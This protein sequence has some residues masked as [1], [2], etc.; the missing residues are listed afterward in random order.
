M[1]SPAFLFLLLWIPQIIVH[2]FWAESFDPFLN[3]AWIIVAIAITGFLIGTSGAGRLKL[4]GKPFR[5]R[6]VSPKWVKRFIYFAP[7]LF[8]GI[9]YWFVVNADSTSPIAIRLAI[10]NAKFAGLQTYEIAI[11]LLIIYSAFCL[12][13]LC[14]VENLNRRLITLL[15]LVGTIASILTTGR[16]QLLVFTIAAIAILKRRG[17]IKTRHMLIFAALFVVLFFGIA[18][19]LGKG[20]GDDGLMEQIGWNL[21]VYLFSSLSCF[22]NFL[23]T[24]SPAVDSLAMM[25]SFLRP[26]FDMLPRDPVNEFAQIPFNCNTYT[27]LFPV[28][29][30]FG[31]IGVLCLFIFLGIFHQRLYMR[32]LQWGTPLSI[33]LYALSLYPLMMTVFED[34]YFSSYG[35]WL[36]FWLPVIAHSIFSRIGFRARRTIPIAKPE[37][38]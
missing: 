17:A 22:N 16:L 26:V 18:V 13:F 7:F 34:A 28:T 2:Y 24:G 20:E 12:Y 38:V 19:V 37:A 14:Y 32:Y 31:S 35:I 25:P 9:I 27:A 5:I 33:Y 11:K 3:E 6:Y 15:L 30:D 10:I 21:Q 23:S 8:V 36:M 1:L 29:H 4:P